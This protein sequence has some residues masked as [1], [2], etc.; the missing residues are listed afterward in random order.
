MDLNLEQ[1]VNFLTR[2]Q[3][4]LDLVFMFHP[5]FK[6][7][8]KPLPPIG[9]KSDHEM[10]LLDTSIQPVST[11]LPHRKIYT[12]K[13]ANADDIRSHFRTNAGQFCSSAQSVEDMWTTFKSALSS[14]VSQ[15]VP[16][17]MSSTRQT[18]PWVDTKLRRHMRR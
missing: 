15:H 12:W 11:R 18:H 2:L 1:V 17:K 3:N 10:V 9:L 5:S 6:I 4:T 7:R 13:K 14:A 16:S 8:C